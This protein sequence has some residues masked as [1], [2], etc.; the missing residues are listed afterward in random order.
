M[1]HLFSSYDL[2]KNKENSNNQN[3]SSNF[4]KQNLKDLTFY[5]F[6]V[7]RTK[8]YESKVAEAGVQL[9]SLLT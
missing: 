1:D 4:D 3:I 7:D 2:G 6:I 9:E 5:S 8:Y